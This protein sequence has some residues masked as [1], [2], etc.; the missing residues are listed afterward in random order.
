IQWPLKGEKSKETEEG[1]SKKVLYVWE[2]EEWAVLHEPD[3]TDVGLKRSFETINDVLVIERLQYPMVNYGLE[4]QFFKEENGE[5][6]M[7]FYSEMQEL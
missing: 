7:I 5:W 4:R 1:G 3:M 6:T 2:P